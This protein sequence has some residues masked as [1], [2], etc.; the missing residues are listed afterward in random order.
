[1]KKD[2]WILEDPNESKVSKV[3]E[4]FQ[5]R[6]RINLAIWIIKVDPSKSNTMT[7]S[8]CHSMP[9]EVC[10]AGQMHPS[11]MFCGSLLGV[12][13]RLEKI[14]RNDAMFFQIRLPLQVFK[15]PIT[16]WIKKNHQFARLI[17][18]NKDQPMLWPFLTEAIQVTILWWCDNASHQ[19]IHIGQERGQPQLLLRPFA[20]WAAHQRSALLWRCA[21]QYVPPI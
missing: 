1:M 5:R 4:V 3:K 2:S 20:W 12:A 17:E 6:K 11:T 18:L 19:Y 16:D 14:Q 9:W 10:L 13:G 21:K 8:T 15:F 7:P